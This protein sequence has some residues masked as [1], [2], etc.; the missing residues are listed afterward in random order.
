[1]FHRT[2][3]ITEFLAKLLVILLGLQFSGAR[4]QDS[5][6]QSTPL[7]P[8]QSQAGS[9]TAIQP[10]HVRTSKGAFSALAKGALPKYVPVSPSDPLDPYILAEAAALNNDPNQIFAFVRDQ[11]GFEAYAGSVRGARG[12]LWAMAGNTLDKASLLIALL[13]ASGYTAQYEHVGGEADQVNLIASM[14]PQTNTF[15]GC[16]PP[17][18]LTDNPF[19]NSAA[20]N[21]TIDYYWVQYGT[22]GSNTISLDPNVPGAAVGQ[23]FQTPAANGTA[24]ATFT[25]VP[26]SLRQQ[27]TIKINAELYSQASSIYAGGPGTTTVLTQSFDAS[28]LVGNIITAG[29]LVSVS[30][31]SGLDFTATTYTY[32]PFLVVGSG[33]PD[34]TQDQLI[35][36]TPYQEFYT[37]FPL[38]SQVLT[39]L[40][41]EIDADDYTYTQ[42]PYIHTMFDRLGPAAR[43]GNAPVALS[44]PSPPAPALTQFD[45]TTVNIM[46]ARQPL[47]SIQAQQTRLTNA[48]NNYESIK[49]QLTSLPTSGQL[50]DAQQ[51]ILQQ[52]TNLGEYLTIAEN[53]LITMSYDYTADLLTKQLETGYYSRVYPDSPRITIASSA[54][55]GGNSQEMLDVLKNDM[56]VLDGYGQNRSAPYWEEVMR[57][58]LESLTESSILDQATGQTNAIGIGEVFGALGDP[59]LLTVIG[60]ASGST[61]SNPE[62]LTSTTLSADAQTLILNDVAVGNVVMTPTQMVTVNGVT[63]VGWWETNPNTGH[64]ISHFVNGGH[65]A[66]VEAVAVNVAKG[67]IQSQIVKFIGGV[68]GN[69]LAGIE[70][71]AAVLDGAA[72]N[73]LKVTKAILANPPALGNLQ[74]PPNPGPILGFFNMTA[75][76]LLSVGKAYAKLQFADNE[77]LQLGLSVYGFTSTVNTFESNLAA[78]YYSGLKWLTANYLKDPDI[79]DFISTPLGLPQPTLNPGATPGVQVGTVTVDPLYTMGINGNELPL[80]F[81]LPITNTGPNTD[82]FKIQISDAIQDFQIYPT[83]NSLTL[84]GGQSGMV[85]LCVVPYDETGAAVPPVGQPQNYTVTVTSSSN[86]SITAAASPS[87]NVPPMPSIEV[88]MDPPVIAATPGEMVSVN[89]NI[90]TVGNISPGPVT[91]KA[92]LPAGISMS[93]LTSP[94]SVPH[95]TAT[96][97]LTIG[98]AP[99]MA[100]GSYAIP[101]TATFTPSGGT[102]QFVNFLLPIN[103]TALGACALSAS[104][105][106]T[107]VGKPN[108]AADLAALEADMNAA[109]ATPSNP[110]LAS[111]VAGDMNTIISQEL[112]TTYFQSVVPNLTAAANAVV[113]ATPATLLTALGNLSTALCSIASLL[114]Q[115]NSTSTSLRLI[116]TTQLADTNLA[117]GPN[118]S[119]QWNIFITNNS[120]VLHVY[121]LST[122][123]VPNGVTVQFSQPSIT[124]PPYPNDIS[125]S[126]LVTL[127][128]GATFNTPI[129]F[130]VVATPQDAP[131]FAVSTPGTLLARPESVNVDQITATPAY[132]NAGTPITI[133]ARVFA[134]V[135]EPVT[136]SLQFSLTDP[137]GHAVCCIQTSSPFTLTPSTTVQTITF[138]PISTTGFINGAYTISVQPEYDYALGTTATASLLIGAPLSGVLSAT[139]SIVPPGSST[140]QAA[141]NITRDTT[142]NPVSTLVGSVPLNGVPRAMTLFQNG[143]QQLA[144]ACSDSQVNIVDVTTPASPT[145]LSTFANNILTTEDGSPV[146]GYQVVACSTYSN[147]GSSYFL[148]SYSRFDGNTTTNPILTHFATYSL[149]NPLVPVQ[150]GSV[151]D[152]ERGDSFGLYVAGTTALMLQST[153]IYDPHSDF[154]F[155][156]TGDV[157]TASL[158]TPGSVNYLNDVYSCGSYNSTTQTCSSVTN[159]PAATESG[160]VCTSTGTTPVPNTQTQGGPYRIGLGTAVNSTT[161]YVASTNANGSNIENP[162]CPAISGQLL[163]VDTT[164]PSSPDILTS[165]SAP[166]MA[167]M[168]G[169]AVQG[170]TA[171]AVGDSIGIHSVNAGYLGSLVLSSFDISNPTSPQLLDSVTTQLTDSP[172]SFVVPLGSNT[173]AVGNTALNGNA[174]LVLV[175]ASNPSA[176]RYIPYNAAFVAN[177]TIAQNGYFF[178]LSSTPASAQ[179][180]LSIFQ[181]SEVAGPQLSVSL[182]LPNS[183]NAA[184]VP[185]SFSPAPTTVTPGTGSTTYVWNQP[186]QTAITFNM[187]LSGVNPGDVTTLVNSG[188]LS[189]TLPT[190]GSGTYPLGSLSVLSQHILSISPAA[191]TV[192]YGATTGNYT[193]TIAN[194]TASQQ[195]FNLSAIVPPGWTGVVPASVT[196]AAN[197][198]QTFNVAITPPVNVMSNREEY[199][200]FNVAASTG[201]GITDTVPANIAVANSG[202]NLG[203]NGSINFGTFTSSIAPSQVTVGRGDYSQSYTITVTN[204]GNVTSSIQANPP[205]S[206][207][208]GL[209]AGGYTPAYYT[210]VSPNASAAI[211]GTVF[212]ARSTTPGSYPLT[213]PVQDGSTI[214]NLGLTVNVSSAGVQGNISPS[215]GTTAAH[216]VLNLTNNG[217]AQDTFNLSVVGPLAQAASIQPTVTMAAGAVN[218]QIPITLGAVNYILP[219]NAQLQ[220]LA[221]SHNDPNVQAVIA[222]T[223]TVSQNKSVTASILPFPHAY[224]TTAPGSVSLLFDATNTGNVSDSYTASITN[225]TGSITATLGNA[226]SPFLVTALGTAQLPLNAALSSGT[227]GTVTVAVTST[228]NSAVTAQS[229][230]TIQVG[231]PSSCDVNQDGYINVLDV[232]IMVNE[233]LGTDSPLNDLDVDGVVN[234]VDVQIDINGAL[235]LGCSTGIQSQSAV[236]PRSH[237]RPVVQ[238]TGAAT[239]LAIAVLP[240]SVTDLGTLGGSSATAFGINNLGQVVGSSDTAQTVS[241]AFLWEGG[242]MTDLGLSDARN[243]LAYCINDASQ[244]AG[245]YSYPDRDTAGFFYA[246]G[247]VTTLSYVPHGRVSAINNIGE[248]VGHL[249]LDTGTSPEAFLWNAGTVID[250]GTLGGTSSQARAIN[251]SGQI[252]GFAYL[253]GNSAIHAFLY[254]GADLAD[255]GTLGGRNSMA[256]GINRTGQIVGASLTPG[257]G[258]QHAFLYSA[259]VMT[260]LGTLGGTESQ[261]DG[262]NDS[263]WAVGWSRTAGGEQHAFLWSSGRMID[264]NSFAAPGSGIRLEEAT[265]VNDVGQIVANAN[266][267]HAY[268]IALPIQFQ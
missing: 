229:T 242:H 88:S 42:T 37:N 257:N 112:T 119:A 145:V 127:T 173:F 140:V 51:V 153:T 249:T 111:R 107:Q 205:A 235:Q 49:P 97:A 93:G 214:E 20:Y 171:L 264:L 79:L 265:A 155:Q 178:A 259:G 148:I 35:T 194:P 19:G 204:T 5:P 251:D 27:V 81:D 61:P 186:V 34:L 101:F 218:Q 108:L 174:E 114:N 87:F 78:G 219:S 193:A 17:N 224:L 24:P 13:G 67:Q 2:S 38:S 238:S 228:S 110:A 172:G 239:N 8:V 129:S 187:N 47:S 86:S 117:V 118:Q 240:Y 234:V 263:G 94:L 156:E 188:Q 200:L 160:G 149:A 161:T 253:G 123:G 260:D 255:L 64:T 244:I 120:P 74:P 70:F 72:A 63:T 170:T 256:F 65:Q 268:L 267:G 221:V 184:V 73:S 104:A 182:Q 262:I 89:L 216:F 53:E 192:S 143:A 169:V 147:Q 243:S 132:A 45:L 207:P 77:G 56:V 71:A 75:S 261:A 125:N 142:Q 9:P 136:G 84:S 230:L 190:L 25:T 18:A 208:A 39:G 150:V 121:N 232:Q 30:G 54:Y 266:N 33:G 31:G 36:G 165:V 4:G 50:T 12:T 139:P 177:P 62:A 246:A 158:S 233:A 43:Q 179:N 212:A 167:F 130:N 6:P 52:G 40:F 60:P 231:T 245:V 57:G 32:T 144:Y 3:W 211:V 168:T 226:G 198:S 210:T 254:S 176:L 236:S 222:A 98:A 124:L 137:N 248:I 113:S 138:S 68:E 195:T 92:T 152:I 55:N 14:F 22:N 237:P 162:T 250:L 163:V 199:Y 164:N 209:S 83:V 16:L 11:V 189:F 180:A 90:A 106:A 100:S 225:T 23:S 181:L 185:G 151:V 220:I 154:I 102:P 206:F 227:S 201:G 59:N 141:L 109:A 80:V 76:L 202:P 1:M 159:V 215:S 46:T 217:L 28:A 7:S 183:G 133:S 91:L 15:V 258:P 103:I 29:N 126:T 58:M 131:E 95:N 116:A 213:I 166:A 69:G 122:T 41:L 196:V 105:V 115:A 21:A 175:D 85:N 66:T 82:T 48:Y 146:A 157:W 44:L 135:N 99:N 191:Q 134:V 241:H 96:E 203:S 252:A 128:T 10:A 26:A 197:S 247:V 223:V